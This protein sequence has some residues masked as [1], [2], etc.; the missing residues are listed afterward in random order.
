[1]RI[2]VLGVGSLGRVIASCMASTP[3]EV[4]LHVRGERGAQ[5]ILEGLKVTGQGMAPVPADRFLFTCE[6]L[7]TPSEFQAQSD[8]VII[9]CKSYDVP[10]LARAASFFLKTDGI[11]FAVSNGLGHAE[12]LNGVLGTKRVVSSTTTHGAFTQPNGE[13]VWAGKGNLRLAKTSLGPSDEAFSSLLKVMADA[14]LSPQLEADPASMVWEKVLL[15]VSI[16][17]IAAL[18]GLRNGEL[19]EPGLFSS[20]MTVYREAA[21]VAQLERIEIPNEVEFE[22][23][24]RG[25]LEAT[26]NNECSML[27]DIKEGRSTE[28]E[29]LN[30]AVV[31]K[32]EEHGLSL[33]VNQLLATLIRSC[34]P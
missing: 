32:G 33:P 11:A 8:I 3:H 12:T 4:H 1:M 23:R 2:T 28:I 17:P 31:N 7:D 25:V 30:Q 15:N 19:L 34:L 13:V 18:A 5:A 10:S 26:A 24:L 27:Q 14:G 6:E 29:T 22:Q 9:A 16:N 20:C 21:K